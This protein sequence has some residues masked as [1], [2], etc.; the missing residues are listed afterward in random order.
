MLQDYRRQTTIKLFAPILKGEQNSLGRSSFASLFVL[1]RSQ[2]HWQTDVFVP[3]NLSLLSVS[4]SSSS[5]DDTVDLIGTNQRSDRRDSASSHS[6]ISLCSVELNEQHMTHLELDSYIFQKHLLGLTS[7]RSNLNESDVDPQMKELFEGSK[8][9]IRWPD[10]D[11][12]PR[13]IRPPPFSQH[14]QQLR[15]SLS[16]RKLTQRRS[17]RTPVR[18]TRAESL[19]LERQQSAS[20]HQLE[21]PKIR[22]LTSMPQPRR[23]VQSVARHSTIPLI[24]HV[25]RS[26]AESDV[27]FRQSESA[28]SCKIALG[29]NGPLNLSPHLVK[30]MR[31][32][33]Q[34]N[35]GEHRTEYNA[36]RISHV[37]ECNFEYVLIESTEAM[38]R[39]GMSLLLIFS[40]SLL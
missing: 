12:Q 10:N 35:R 31:Q 20:E 27:T 9:S 30:Q 33:I 1:D 24:K 15:K 23:S 25:A 13:A 8:S 37:R 11:Y 28:R 4:N 19:K 22:P 32:D 29:V 3:T 2:K 40:T 26:R 14:I 39:S 7:T 38:N 18:M 34:S 36:V 16:P 17:A 21:V 6:S 5:S